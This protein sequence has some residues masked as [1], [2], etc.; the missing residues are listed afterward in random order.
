MI[1]GGHSSVRSCGKRDTGRLPAEEGGDFQLF[2]LDS[3]PTHARRRFLGGR[4]SGR[5]PCVLRYLFLSPPFRRWALLHIFL[6]FLLS[7]AKSDL[8][9]PLQERHAL[10]VER[11]MLGSLA[12][13]GANLLLRRH[14][15]FI[16]MR[17]ARNSSARRRSARP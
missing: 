9:E 6:T 8:R 5:P 16:D 10:L 3:G 1:A 15:Q 2:F 11:L 7:S 17:H 13:A 4:T 14:R 12:A